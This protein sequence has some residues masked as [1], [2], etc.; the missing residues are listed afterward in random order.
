MRGTIRTIGLG[1]ALA[2]SLGATGCWTAAAAGAGAVAGVA[3]T[4]RGAETEVNGSVAQVE[5]RAQKVLEQQGIAIAASKV[6]AGGSKRV[7][8]GKHGDLNVTI[9]MVGTTESQTHVEV[10]AQKNP[11]Q[12]DKDYAKQLAQNIAKA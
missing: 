11:V 9:T 5:K 7:L 4:N 2:A 10:V 12:W 1:V 6:E 3:Y 8:E